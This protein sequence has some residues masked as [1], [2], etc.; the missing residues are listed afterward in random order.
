MMRRTLPLLILLALLASSCITVA[1]ET[2]APVEPS[3]VT[4]TLPPTRSLVIRLTATGSPGGTG[5]PGTPT[6][7]VTAPP[8]CKVVAVLI[9]DVTIPDGTS[10]SAGKT[11]TKTW[12]FKNTG[13]CPWVGYKLAYV[14]GDRM[15]AP[16][17]A[18]VD[19][20]LAGDLVNVSVDLA[21]PLADGSY[22]GFFELQD[23]E[24]QVVPIGLEKTFW[25]KIVV[26]AGGLP[27]A[28]SSGSATQTSGGGSGSCQVTTNA[29]YINDLLALINAARAEAG[30]PAVTLNAQLSAAAQGHSDDMACH[31]LISH[32]GSDGSS[33]G[34]RLAAAGYSPSYYI[35]VIAIGTPQDAMSQ[36][37]DDA[38]HRN[39]LIDR[40]VTEIGIGYAFSSASS[41]GGHITVDMASP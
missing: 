31:S 35:E 3:F 26:G 36:W 22:T 13:T 8:D 12:K 38:L 4:S 33:I 37:N 14:S 9:E 15:G 16:E 32:T 23:A 10:I 6:L 39:A 27:I 25:V 34:Q 18:P 28:T 5:T 7:A 24:G 29:A 19:Q 1:S 17:T 11:F 21:A 2:E 40:N 41:Y 30:A 20:T